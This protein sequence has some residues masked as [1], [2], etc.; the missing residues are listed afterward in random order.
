MIEHLLLNIDHV[1][2]PDSE[3]DVN[4]YPVNCSINSVNSLVPGELVL[5]WSVDGGS[6][7]TQV[8]LSPV[9]GEAYT[10]NYTAPI[11]A[12]SYGTTVHYYL[13]AG[14]VDGR[15]TTDPINAPTG[16][17]SFF[18][19]IDAIPPVIAHNPLGDQSLVQW[20]STVS[21]TVTDNQGIDTATL[22]FKINGGSVETVPMVA[23]GDGVFAADFYGLASVGDMIEYRIT[24]VDVAMTPNSSADPTT[25]YN[26]FSIVEQTPV[27]IFEP[28]GTPLSGAAIATE[29][30]VL[31]IDY[32]MGTTLP[33]N[34]NLYRSIFA[35]LGVYS[36]NHTLTSD[37]GTALAGFLDN[38]GRVYMEGGD[39]WA[40]DS[41]TLVHPYFNIDGL[42]DGASDA[43][44]ISGAVGTFTDGMS[45]TYSGNNSWMDRIAP[46]GGAWAIF[47]NVTPA[48]INGVANNGG[49]YRTIGTSF[50]FGGL[51]DAASPS[52]KHDL[53]VEIIEFFQMDNLL[54]Q[55]F[56]DGFES[57]DLSGWSSVSP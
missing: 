10:N 8:P 11:P 25:G 31:G 22:E 20:P 36:T 48:Y 2:M 33:S 16:L 7:F 28:D 40:F 15:T 35:C 12:Q 13:A 32:D 24:A 27:Y 51:D 37:E 18:V 21:A 14:N 57:G 56:D 30:D 23:Q 39:T 4:P 38:G 3:D 41:E 47:L 9:A 49:T 45:F 54:P 50:E 19:G 55:I 1:P 46:T 17:H 43:G 29:L 44:P 34:P 5:H 26:M 52:T 53:L 42:S 6:I